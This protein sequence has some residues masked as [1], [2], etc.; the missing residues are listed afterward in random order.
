MLITKSGLYDWTVM[1]FGLKNATSTF[2]RTMSEVFK[3]L[4]DKFLKVFVDDL[5]IHNESWEDHL[6]YL[7]ALLS[8]LKEVN[9]KLNPS[10]CCFDA[11][12]IVFLGHVVNK[13][14]TKLD[15]GKIDVVL[16]FPE[17]KTITNVRSFLGLTGYYRKYI[18]GYSRM[19][20]PLFE[21]TK[22]DVEFVWNQNCQRAFDD[23]KRA[24]VEAPILVRLDFKEPFCLDVDWSTKGVGA[25]LSQREG[26]FEK[27]VAYASKA[28]T[29]AQRKFHPMEGEC[30]ALIWG[31]LHFI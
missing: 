28:L 11:E 25:V 14:G 2:T 7:G 1:S 15:P 4:G 16:R 21:L 20:S 6:Q 27:V 5:N 30:Y 18:R 13:E 23:L 19:A 12:S 24:L 26:G 8:K 17:P 3:D 31:I 22:K 9:L 29:V 10:K